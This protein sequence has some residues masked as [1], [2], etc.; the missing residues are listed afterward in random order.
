GARH[1]FLT[2]AGRNIANPTAMLLCGVNLLQYLNLDTMAQRIENAIST[3]IKQ[4]RIKTRDIGGYATQQD[5]LRSI[6]KQLGY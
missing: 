5:F 6:L 1:P 4:Q 2:G 3:V